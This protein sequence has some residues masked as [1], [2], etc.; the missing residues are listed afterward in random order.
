MVDYGNTENGVYPLCCAWDEAAPVWVIVNNEVVAA[1]YN[2]PRL[3]EYWFAD[4]DGE[5]LEA[6]IWM[7]R[8]GEVPPST[9][10]FTHAHA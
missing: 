3:D 7:D 6:T 1:W 2:N 8:T 4:D 9:P 10:V 5:I